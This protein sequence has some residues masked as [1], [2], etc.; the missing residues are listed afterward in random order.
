VLGIVVGLAWWGGGTVLVGLFAGKPNGGAMVLFVG[1]IA[2]IVQLFYLASLPRARTMLLAMVLTT[3][4]TP[5]LLILGLIGMC[6]GMR[7]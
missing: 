3:V 7:L 1:A 2:Y 4:L 5:V 6:A